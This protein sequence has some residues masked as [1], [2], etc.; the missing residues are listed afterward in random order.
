MTS[1][2]SH[3][4][5]GYYSDRSE[6]CRLCTSVIIV[7]RS[8]NFQCMSFQQR[9]SGKAKNSVDI[10]MQHRKEKYSFL[11]VRDVSDLQ[12]L[13]MKAEEIKKLPIGTR[14]RGKLGE[15]T[16]IMSSRYGKGVKID[17]YPYPFSEDIHGFGQC[18]DR[19]IEGLV[20]EVVGE[21]I[22]G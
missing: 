10:R 9:Q 19:T 8:L 18:S 22:G 21:L 6:V 1:E 14:V 7:E 17:T 20:V 11:S 13:S 5:I 12:V 15:G 3:N 16:I 2:S 4:S